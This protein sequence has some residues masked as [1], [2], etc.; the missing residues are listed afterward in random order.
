MKLA[1]KI[2]VG[3]VF[4]IILGIIFG[5][6]IQVVQIVGDLFLKLLTMVVVPLIF[7]NVVAG[8]SQMDDAS[9]FGRAG[10]KLVGYYLFTMTVAVLLGVISGFLIQ[11]GAGVTLK[12]AEKAAQS[13]EQPTLVKVLSNFVPTN[14]IQA[15]AEGKLLQVIVFAIFIGLGILL[16][17]KKEKDQLS[18]LFRRLSNLMIKV[19][20]LV[21]ELSPYGIAAL[22]AVT[23]GKYGPSIFG[24]MIKYVGAIYLAA[25]AQVVIVYFPL[26]YLFTRIGPL[27]FAK[28][29]LPVWVTAATTCSSQAS[30]PVEYKTCEENLGL[31]TNICNFSLPLGATMN[32]DGNALWFGVIALF[33]AQIVGI[34]VTGAAVLQIAF[35]GVVLSLGSPGI[36]GGI[37][38]ATTAF[39]TGMGYPLEIAAMLMGIFR[40]MD[41]GLTT[42]NVTGDVVGATLVSKWEKM[43]DRKTSP[44]WDGASTN[45]KNNLTV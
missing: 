29:T 5:P 33:T 30:L 9:K 3:M 37:F 34:P 1:T 20:G 27:E 2:V 6:K 18:D 21:M 15:M 12:A 17:N 41:I 38:V 42:L 44:L 40:L 13:V 24:P 16:L 25:I 45:T 26:L 31:P 14:G 36:P 32:Q 23:V 35:L 19:I 4:G 7:V 11:P 10:L 22:S 8:I 39:L 28:R 43:F